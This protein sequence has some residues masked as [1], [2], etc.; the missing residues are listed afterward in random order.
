[1]PK[2]ISKR[3]AEMGEEA[4]AKYQVERCR[5][6]DRRYQKKNP[7]VIVDWRRN[8]KLKLI[9]YKGGKCEI[10][11]YNKPYP[12]CYEFHH[13]DQSKKDFTIGKGMKKFEVSKK[14][15]D[16]CQ[17]LC[18]N[19]H[20]EVHEKLDDIRRAETKARWRDIVV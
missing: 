5:K 14:E 15:V 10:C 2:G 16:K 13:K 18:R 3:R 6:K 7:E 8:T 19:C 4:W 17:L 12:R 1:M 20:G 11:G 9:E